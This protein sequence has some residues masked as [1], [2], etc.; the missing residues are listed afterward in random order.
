MSLRLLTLLTCSVFAFHCFAS[1]SEDEEDQA[2]QSILGF[3]SND[4]SSLSGRITIMDLEIDEQRAQQ[5]AQALESNRSLTSLGLQNTSLEDEAFKILLPSLITRPNLTQLN[6]QDNSLSDESAAH[7]FRLL[8]KAKSL[9]N[10]NLQHNALTDTG[11]GFTPEEG[12][13]GD[14]GTI[15]GAFVSAATLELIDLTGNN[16]SPAAFEAIANFIQNR[17]RLLLQ[18]PRPQGSI[19]SVIT[20]ELYALLTREK[21]PTTREWFQDPTISKFEQERKALGNKEFIKRVRNVCLKLLA[22]PAEVQ[23]LLTLEGSLGLA[24]N[25]SSVTQYDP[26]FKHTILNEEA[27]C[28]LAEVLYNNTVLQDL[29]LQGVGLDGL[30]NFPLLNAALLSL[31]ALETL[32]L[33]NNNLGDAGALLISQIL[34]GNRTLRY[35][36][37]ANN[38]ITA[39]GMDALGDAL[40]QSNVLETLNLTSNPMGDRGGIKLAAAL[41]RNKSLKTLLLAK[42]QM[43]NEGAIALAGVLGVHSALVELSLFGNHIQHEGLTAFLNAR[44]EL[45]HT[46]DIDLHQNPLDSQ[47]LLLFHTNQAAVHAIQALTLEEQPRQ[48]G[49]VEVIGRTAAEEEAELAPSSDPLPAGDEEAEMEMPRVIP[50]SRPAQEPRN[51]LYR[52][53]GWV[54]SPSASVPPQETSMPNPALFKDPEIAKYY[55]IMTTPQSRERLERIHGLYEAL[56][57]SIK[58]ILSFDTCMYLAF[59]DHRMK[60]VNLSYLELGQEGLNILWNALSSNHTLTALKLVGLGIDALQAAQLASHVAMN[61]TLVELN[62]SHNP[63]SDRGLMP[64][65][66]ALRVQKNLQALNLT[67]ITGVTAQ[68]LNYLIIAIKLIELKYLILDQI[69]FTIESVFALKDLLEQSPPLEMLSL[70][71][72]GLKDTDGTFLAQAL[73]TNKNLTILNLS[74]NKL[75]NHCLKTLAKSLINHP[76]LRELHLEG[77][78]ISHRGLEALITLLETGRSR[79]CRITYSSGLLSEARE[80]KLNEL[81]E[82]NQF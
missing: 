22:L 12:I 72:T 29:Y 77:N 35:L 43:G 36:G 11:V 67:G 70:A 18:A 66:T 53:W 8:I 37:L 25:A 79:L 23:N 34:P 56:P 57:L 4:T 80:R 10:L 73:K 33:L 74:N 9:V 1:E 78:P 24:L 60:Q 44:E 46:V 38:K 26:V 51:L 61:G 50:R 2:W 40:G 14:P 52:M 16:L 42:T 27:T 30:T 75:S 68:G 54:S 71:Q 20:P 81:L 21:V 31:S 3:I 17:K 5:L 64:L 62:I 48:E 13:T 32:E 76:T 65:A 7:I 6:L 47:D 49:H 63:I 69:P 19:D 41:R 58:G 45:E 82:R 39:R 15:M 59:N 55:R 28:L